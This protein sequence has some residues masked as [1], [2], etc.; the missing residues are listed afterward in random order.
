MSSD[1]EMATSASKRRGNR[2]TPPKASGKKSKKELTPEVADEDEGGDDEEEYEI[3]AILDCKKGMFAP[4]RWAFYVSW[5]GYGSDDNSWVD[6]PDFFAKDMIEKWWLDNPSIKGNPLAGKKA[7]GRKSETTSSTKGKPRKASTEEEEDSKSSSKRKSGAAS[8]SK[9]RASEEVDVTPEVVS[10]EEE[11]PKKKSR[12]KKKDES[13]PPKN[14]FFDDAAEA[15]DLGEHRMDAMSQHMEK[16]S[17]EK[18]IKSIET[19]ERQEDGVLL[20]YY[21]STDGIRAI[22]N[23]KVLAEKAPQKLITFYEQNLRWRNTE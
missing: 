20:V 9:K 14:G 22:S 11:R 10:E 13:P 7:K 3:E 19:V 8:S 16:K 15:S 21:S 1:A 17:W 12:T 5:K 4:N 23:A 6:E 18:L 2:S